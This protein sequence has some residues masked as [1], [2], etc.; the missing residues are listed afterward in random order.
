MK[1]ITNLTQLFF[2]LVLFN[3]LFSCSTQKQAY[4]NNQYHQYTA[5]KIAPVQSENEV[6]SASTEEVAPAVIENSV[7]PEAKAIAKP[8]VKAEAKK[9]VVNISKEE[10]AARVKNLTKAEKKEIRKEIKKLSKENRDSPEVATILLVI[11][12]IIIPPLAVFLVDGLE[13][14]FWL[15]LLLTLLFFLPGIIYALYRIFKD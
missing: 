1:K 8:S 2:T 15:D 3:T 6:V 11:L 12:A 4:V 10:I 13:L 14:P 9:E 7:S 5:E